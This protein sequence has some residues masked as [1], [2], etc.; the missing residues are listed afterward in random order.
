M[1]FINGKVGKCLSNPMKTKVEMLESDYTNLFDLRRFLS[2][3]ALM[4]AGLEKEWKHV[5]VTYEGVF[6][7]SVI[8]SMGVHVVKDKNI[9]MED[10]GYDDPYTNIKVENQE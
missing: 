6:E 2:H 1:V 3:G 10:I 4:D 9:I 7:T 5:E 8:K